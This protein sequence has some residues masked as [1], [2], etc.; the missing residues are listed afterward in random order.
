M[1]HKRSTGGVA[2]LD[3]TAADIPEHAMKI[4][5]MALFEMT[6]RILRQP[7]G[8]EMLDAE[9][10]RRKAARAAGQTNERS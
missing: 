9:T 2:H 10:A 8:R 6:E 5:G 3:F 1:Y 7:G 4:A